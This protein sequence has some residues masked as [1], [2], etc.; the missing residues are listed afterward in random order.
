LIVILKYNLNIFSRSLVLV[1]IQVSQR[2][3]NPQGDDENSE[4][5]INC[6]KPSVKTL[7]SEQ[8]KSAYAHVPKDLL[9]L[10]AK[11][12]KFKRQ[13]QAQSIADIEET[14]TTYHE[15][16]TI[17]QTVHTYPPVHVNWEQIS[18]CKQPEEPTEKHYNEE[19]A[20]ARL[21]NYKPTVYDKLFGTPQK[22]INRL[23]NYIDQ[24]RFKDVV[25][26]QRK[27][28][29]Y[30]EEL[31]TWLALK[32]LCT[33]FEQGE[34]KAHKDALHF[35]NPFALVEALGAQVGFH[36]DGDKIDFDVYIN[37][38]TTIPDYEFNKV[39]NAALLKCKLSKKAFNTYLK[40]H[41]CSVA[42]KIARE[43]SDLIPVQQIRTNIYFK[44]VDELQQTNCE[45]VMSILFTADKLAELDY[46]HSNLNALL[47]E[48]RRELHFNTYQGFEPVLKVN[49]ADEFP[50]F[51]TRVN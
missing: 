25:E 13:Q 41:I 7:L 39:S 17:L 50:N 37:P 12:Q 2:K 35:F 33:G 19:K 6:M 23:E 20:K 9:N 24:A 26:N 28:Q 5:K 42:L 46:E 43:T 21:A 34:L 36:L 16:C 14:L 48:F 30:E 1:G 3:L 11:V 45:R 31:N 51:L 15:Y 18:Q 27:K 32:Q 49:F 47:I 22:E 8:S 44:T 29:Q 4:H 10:H 40:N 38:E